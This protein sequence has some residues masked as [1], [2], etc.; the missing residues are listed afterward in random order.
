[1]ST[2][3]RIVAAL[4]GAANVLDAVPCSAR[5]RLRVADPSRV[6]EAA[7]RA[8]GVLAV[9]RSEAAIQVVVGREADALA[10]D[11]LALRR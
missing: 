8:C 9:V 7:L 10:A 4:G 6:D 2:A 11:I 1:M 3:E 5:L